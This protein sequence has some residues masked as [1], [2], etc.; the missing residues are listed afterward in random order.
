[1]DP[2]AE[3][4]TDPGSTA[5]QPATGPVLA[6][7]AHPDDAEI[8]AGGTLAR[9]CAEGLPVD[10]LVLTNGDRGSQDPE[11]D[12]ADLARIRREETAAAASVIGFRSS[13][14]LEIH[15]GD[16]EN[17]PEVREQVV[18]VLRRLRPEIVVTCDPTVTFF[19]SRYFNH[20]DHRTA[21]IV[22][23]DSVFPGAGN[24]HYFPEQLAD[25]L[26]PWDV[27]EVWLA[28]TTEPNHHH[29]ITGHLDRKMEALAR[30]ASQVKGGM[31]GF[32]EEWLPKE[33]VEAGQQIGVE[34]AE[35]FRVLHLS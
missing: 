20:A 3:G 25:G 8:A 35:A 13:Q 34:H 2:D 10:L 19:G 28:W 5:P 18:R 9:W 14:I 21:G 29:D 1:M 16:L 22:A 6:C 4:V 31:L 26:R 32:F 15:D 24:P 27:P 7:F 30:H 12:R 33:A 17:T 23:L 11:Q